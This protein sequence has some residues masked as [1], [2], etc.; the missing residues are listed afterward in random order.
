MLGLAELAAR[1]QDA[2]CQQLLIMNDKVRLPT[3]THAKVVIHLSCTFWYVL[4]TTLGISRGS[5]HGIFHNWSVIGCTATRVSRD[6]TTSTLLPVELPP[7]EGD[8]VQC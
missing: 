5:P 1:V 7:P 8:P 6:V 3:V 2:G 4:Y